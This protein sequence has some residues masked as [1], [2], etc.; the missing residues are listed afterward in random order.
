MQKNYSVIFFSVEECVITFLYY[1]HFR[2]IHE[3]AELALELS[4][5]FN[6][7]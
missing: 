3:I 7:L 4:E 5:H 2:L 6:S 1:F